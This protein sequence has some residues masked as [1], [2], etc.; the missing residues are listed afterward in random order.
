MEKLELSLEELR[1]L[2]RIARNSRNTCGNLYVENN[3]IIYKVFKD[4]Y[5]FIGEKERNVDRLSKLKTDSPVP[6]DKIYIN[7]LFYGYT[8]KF[9]KDSKTFTEGL[10]DNDL[11]LESKMQIIG[12]IYRQLKVL[13]ENGFVIG[14]IHLDNFIYSGNKGYIID[15]EDVRIPGI[16]D[17]KFREYYSI[18]R[19]EKGRPEII[20]SKRTDNI[21]TLISSLSLLVG[22]NLE[23]TAKKYGTEKVYELVTPFIENEEFKY[24]VYQVLFENTEEPLY[25]DDFIKERIKKEYKQVNI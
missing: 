11:G 7:G 4:R 10:N 25:L 24:Y 12:D 21:K 18:K 20:S 16:D 6:I 8:E 9:I 15:L 2:K 1:R 17:F 3:K 23:E 19:N 14:D 13:H 22:F 5:F